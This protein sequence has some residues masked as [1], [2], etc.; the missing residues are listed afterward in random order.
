MCVFISVLFLSHSF[1]LLFSLSP[2]STKATGES[3]VVELSEA[4]VCMC[5]RVCVCVCVCACVCVRVRVR[6]RVHVHVCT[7]MCAHVC[8]QVQ[9]TVSFEVTVGS[10]GMSLVDREHGTT[11]KTIR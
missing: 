11:A 5:V 4:L 8:V 6:V 9:V 2:F 10:A 1:S 3:P 7:Y